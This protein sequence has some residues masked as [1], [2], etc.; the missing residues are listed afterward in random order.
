MS[1]RRS[2]KEITKLNIAV[3]V[4]VLVVIIFCVVIYF[5]VQNNT[6]KE[7]G[8]IYLKSVL[9]DKIDNEVLKKE[10]YVFTSYEEYKKVFGTDKLSE[11]DFKNNN[12]LLLSISYNPCS[13]KEIT[14]TNYSVN[15]N[16]IKVTVTYKSTCGGCA[17]ENV[18]YLLKINKNITNPN[19][20]IEYKELSK[21]ECNPNID[22]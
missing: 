1:L 9:S 17:S 3:L 7:T 12:Y 22:Y 16:N 13:E 19:V 15:G 4:I 8:F 18:Y 2:R 11:S 6:S 14:P 20:N 5:T 21:E 10:N